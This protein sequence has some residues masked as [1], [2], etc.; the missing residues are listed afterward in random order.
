V[1]TQK[2]NTAEQ[3]KVGDKRPS[4]TDIS[5]PSTKIRRIQPTKIGEVQEK[6]KSGENEV[7]NEE[8]AEETKNGDESKEE[9]ASQEPGPSRLLNDQTDELKSLIKACRRVEPS[10]DMKASRKFVFN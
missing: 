8:T 1:F 9:E 10:E 3:L 7:N 6:T 4:E 5:S 2:T